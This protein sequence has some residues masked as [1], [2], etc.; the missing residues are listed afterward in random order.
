M[1]LLIEIWRNTF[2][3]VLILILF[4]LEIYNTAVLPAIKGTYETITAKAESEAAAAKAK[5]VPR[6]TLKEL[7]PTPDADS[8]I[9]PAPTKHRVWKSG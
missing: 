8:P 2:A 9:P 6:P 4:A 5:G 3:R 1:Q 7:I